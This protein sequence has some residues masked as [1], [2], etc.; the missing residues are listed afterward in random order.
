MKGVWPETSCER[1]RL[2][3]SS[4][5]LIELSSNGI[6]QSD[7]AV[8]V[9]IELSASKPELHFETCLWDT[10]ST[11]S[12]G[13]TGLTVID[14]NAKAFISDPRFLENLSVFL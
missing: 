11:F 8:T 2:P 4:P 13:T 14:P 7:P 3:R 9:C 12:E 10:A 5:G 1:V 6:I